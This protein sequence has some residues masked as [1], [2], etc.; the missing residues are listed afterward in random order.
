MMDMVE[1]VAR[2]LHKVETAAICADFDAQDA[3]MQEYWFES[4]RAALAA[5]RE[6]TEAMIRAGNNCLVLCDDRDDRAALV[7][8][9]MIDAAEGR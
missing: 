2:A 7:F 9:A 3:Y 4:A 5:L 6:P 8:S 1:R